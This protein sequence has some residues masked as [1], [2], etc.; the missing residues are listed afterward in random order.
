MNQYRHILQLLVVTL[1]TL[2]LTGCTGNN[3]HISTISS[4]TAANS[5]LA[6]NVAVQGVVVYV[7]PEASKGSQGKGIYLQ[8]LTVD[9]DDSP[10][11]SEGVFVD[12]DPAQF[13]KG[14]RVIIQGNMN[15]AGQG[16]TL[17]D[18]VLIER[19]SSDALSDTQPMTLTLPLSSKLS[20][21][22]FANMWVV[23]PQTLTMS[24]SYN[25]GRYGHV[26]LSS[27]RLMIPTELHVDGSKQHTL[28]SQQNKR[29]LLLMDD[30]TQQQNP[31]TYLPYPLFSASDRL[32]TGTHISNT[33]G[34]MS[35]FNG[36]PI[37]LPFVD[38]SM[39]I[40]WQQADAALA[41][42]PMRRQDS[43]IRIATFNVLNYFTTLDTR[44][45]DTPEE[46]KRQ[47]DKT[48]V[49]I[50]GS[51]ADVIGLV[52]IEN[53]GYGEQSAVAT[54]V[55]ALNQG[56]DNPWQYITP[57]VDK[58]GSASISVAIIYRAK[59]LQPVGEAI[60]IND[61]PFD[62]ETRRHRTP[63]LQTFK[64]VDGDETFSFVVNHFKSKGSSCGEPSDSKTQG[65]CNGARTEAAERLVSVLAQLTKQ[66]DISDNLVVTGDLNAYSKEDPLLVFENANYDNIVNS[67]NNNP[68]YSYVYSHLSGSLDHIL[69][70]DSLTQNAVQGGRWH[71]NADYSR[72]LDYNLE[73]KSDEQAQRL[74]QIDPYRSSDHDPVWLDLQFSVV[75]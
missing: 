70:T 71:I 41:Q 60:H 12:I 30:G 11:T 4:L 56:A 35:S 52:E 6:V 24:Q 39:A 62:A 73:Y 2:T 34:V 55:R 64:T 19:V 16:I 44:G 14:E 43:D 1:I 58:L 20:F 29:D 17:E 13:S 69:V 42:L 40:T 75:E 51:D 10:A 61:K 27:R 9:M 72:R 50:N 28:L 47:T 65:N 37:L 26:G 32:P 31:S 57:T 54:L 33:S 45:A 21:N 74:Y 68:Q 22:S 23:M 36:Q 8:S 48:V 5:Q 63:L 15:S 67:I 7:E 49:A 18:A 66:G 46:L 3:I 38:S 53:N 59:R 25:F